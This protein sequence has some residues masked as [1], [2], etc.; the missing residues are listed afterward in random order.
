MKTLR[1]HSRFLLH[2][3]MLVLPALLFSGS[4][5]L[6]AQSVVKGTEIVHDSLTHHIRVEFGSDKEIT[7]VLVL[8]TDSLGNTLYLDNQYFF[9]GQYKHHFDM[10]GAGKGAYTVQVIKDGERIRKKIIIH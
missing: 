7:N 10:A 3:R 4:S 6:L 2:I 8:I 9:K 5:R 1:Y